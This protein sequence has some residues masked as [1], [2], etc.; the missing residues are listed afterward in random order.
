MLRGTDAYACTQ[1]DRVAVDDIVLRRALQLHCGFQPMSSSRSKIG[2]L[3]I[4]P[5]SNSSSSGHAM[6]F[7]FS[8]I[9]VVCLMFVACF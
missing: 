1:N 5:D 8:L 6:P 7:F 9:S 4:G 3:F 2:S